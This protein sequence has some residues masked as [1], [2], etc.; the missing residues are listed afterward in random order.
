MEEE[1]LE[2]IGEMIGKLVKNSENENLREEVRN[3]VEA[4]MDEFE[5]Y[6]ETDIEY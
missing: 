2:E 4:L 1:E 6:R 3:R 5:L